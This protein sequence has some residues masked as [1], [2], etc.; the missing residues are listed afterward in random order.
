MKYQLKW[1]WGLI[2]WLFVAYTGF[3][4]NVPQFTGTSANTPEVAFT[5]TVSKYAEDLKVGDEVTVCFTG[6]VIADGWHLY[7]A[8]KDGAIGYNATELI[9]FED[10]TKGAALVGNMTENKK[11]RE[12]NDEIMGLVRD[13]KEKEVRFCQKVKITEKNVNIVGEFSAQTCVDPDKGGMCK[14]LNLD[15]NW[16]FTAQDGGDAPADPPANDGDPKEGTADPGETDGGNETTTDGNGGDVE[17]AVDTAQAGATPANEGDGPSESA[18]KTEM[19]VAGPFDLAKA[20]QIPISYEK[21]AEVAAQESKG[22]EPS[23]IWNIFLIAFGAGLLALF[24][25]CVF[26]MI[27]MTVSYFVKQ[28]EG[29][30]GNARARGIRNG[31]TY[32]LSII[33]IYTGL[34]LGITALFGPT[35][36]YQ[37]ASH[38][39]ANFIFFVIF[40]IFAMS[41]FGLFDL[42]L[43]SSLTSRVSSKAGTG[44]FMGL[45]F[46][47]LT[48]VLVSFSCTGPILGSLVVGVANSGCFYSPVAGF[49]AFGL[50]FGI[51]FGLLALF[52]SAL[53]SLPSSGGWLNS[54]KVVLGFLELALCMKFL[55][56]A[57]LIWH[58]KFLNREV[59]I[60]IWIVI[61]ALLGLYLLGKIRL[62]HDDKVEKVSVPR[63]M[64]AIISFSFVMYLVPGLHGTSLHLIEGFLPGFNENVGVKL[65]PGQV[66]GT[67]S[68]NEEI[69][70]LE[71]R[72]YVDILGE[73]ESTGF[74]MF[75]DLQQALYYAQSKNLPVFVDF[76]GHSCANCREME[77][78]VWVV[79]R[80]RRLL[81]EEVVM[82][83]LFADERANL[84]EPIITPEG[85]KLRRVNDFVQYFQST[86]YEVVSQPYYVMLDPYDQTDL[87]TPIGYS[88]EEEFYKLLIDGIAEFNLRHGEE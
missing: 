72:K 39:V 4:Q 27:P 78:S 52:P 73:H 69:G 19:T 31:L 80:V 10:D 49:F 21:G 62:P 42:T 23:E 81:E 83:A 30:E 6:K 71:G 18:P 5:M 63:L 22:C 11:P 65:L 14:F 58:W 50:A 46:M 33:L 9:F 20:N 37:L 57:D 53:K 12:V 64:L 40:V 60:G 68:P 35:A 15:F 17:A 32:A 47:A 84:D 16:K 26:P 77:N 2:L 41:F 45:F 66:A 67:G 13:F 75:F 70:R 85:K 87:A 3:S 74:N 1:G 8:R 34:G 54:V 38:P 24:T 56:N 44:G 86:K 28:N 7:S 48:L 76:T 61:F 29:E 51:P 55:S 25:P 88:S 43:P 36:L 79:E 59:F 82:V